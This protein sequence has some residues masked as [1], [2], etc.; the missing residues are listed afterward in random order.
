MTSYA[1]AEAVIKHRP[2]CEAWHLLLDKMCVALEA[3]DPAMAKTSALVDVRKCYSERSRRHLER[4]VRSKLAWLD[5]L[6]RQ[7]GEKHSC[8]V[9]LEA[10]S[11]LLVHLGRAHVLENVGLAFDHTTGLPWI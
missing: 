11:K 4:A 10:D 1:A 7:F 9:V 2:R 5:R 3:E 6:E 8:R